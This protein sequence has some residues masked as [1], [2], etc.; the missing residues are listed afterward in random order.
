MDQKTGDVWLGLF[1][2]GL[3]R[4]SGGRFDHFHQLNSGLV[5]D[6]VY[7]VAVENDNVW[8]ATTAGA[9]RYNTIT[10]EWTIFTEKNAPME[11][12]WNYAVH[13][14]DGKVHLAVWGSGV[15]EYDVPRPDAGRTTSTPTAKWRSTST[16]TTASSTSSPPGASYVETSSGSRPTSASRRYDGRHWRGYYDHESR[17][18]QQLH[19]QR[20]RPQLAT[21]ALVRTDKGVGAS[22]TRPTNTWVTYTRDPA[23]GR[24]QGRGVPRAARCS[25]TVEM[26]RWHAAQL[27]HLRRLRRPRRLGGDRQGPRL[28]RS[29][30]ATI[31]AS[32]RSQAAYA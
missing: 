9:S 20:P 14:A 32:R 19:Q 31:P 30:R 13:Y 29:A 3:A 12:I 1:G 5:N 18:A 27:H 21:E 2:G 17:P 10:D 25:K 28:G 7:G 15:L 4:F 24:G 26:P 16:A 11:E 22:P 6:V 23:T 8:A